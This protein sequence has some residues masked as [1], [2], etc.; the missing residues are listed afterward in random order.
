MLGEK[1]SVPR[2][3]LSQILDITPC[4]VLGA[5]IVRSLGHPPLHFQLDPAGHRFLQLIRMERLEALRGP[6]PALM[7]G[8]TN[9]PPRHCGGH[10]DAHSDGEHKPDGERHAAGGVGGLGASVDT[11]SMMKPPTADTT[12]THNGRSKPGAE[13]SSPSAIESRAIVMKIPRIVDFGWR[14]ALA[15]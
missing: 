7:P 14:S 3:R 8:P 10:R 13:S 11:A 4:R 9:E 12:V 5:C 15:S 2:T 6:L 1:Q